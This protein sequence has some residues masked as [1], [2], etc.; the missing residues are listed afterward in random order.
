VTVQLVTKIRGAFNDLDGTAVVDG[1]DARKSAVQIS[2]NADS[3]DTRISV[4]V[5]DAVVLGSHEPALGGEQD[6]VGFGLGDRQQLVEQ[7]QLAE[8]S[9]APCPRQHTRHVERGVRAVRHRIGG[10]IQTA[11][12]MLGQFVDARMHAR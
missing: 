9:S 3:I 1:T 11:S 12:V 10:F 6:Q 2:I 7:V 5:A 4:V 8:S